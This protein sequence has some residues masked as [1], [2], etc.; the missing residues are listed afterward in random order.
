M[1]TVKADHLVNGTVEL[2]NAVRPSLLMQSIDILGEYRRDGVGLLRLRYD[3][4]SIVG[5]RLRHEVVT[6]GAVG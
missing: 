5:F 3:V 6:S 1:A 4:V 2:D